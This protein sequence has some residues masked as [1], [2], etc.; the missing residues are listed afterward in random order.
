MQSAN[1]ERVILFI[2]K[3]LMWCV[4]VLP[5]YISTSMFF[6]FITGRNFAFRIIVELAF[7]LW[8]G[9]AI[10]KKEYRPKITPIFIS[11]SIFVVIVF[12]ADIFGV[13][14]YRSFF[15]IMKEWRV[16]L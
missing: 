3:V 6:L 13:D 8:T 15:L 1:L 2:T 7:A 10:A 4:P 9:L 5:I 16:L 12:L 14:P 11:V